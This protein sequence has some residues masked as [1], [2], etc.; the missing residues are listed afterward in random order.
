M[1]NLVIILIVLLCGLQS[2]ASNQNDSL[3]SD[4]IT[5]DVV[6]KLSSDELIL[7]IKDLEAMKYSDGVEFADDETQFI[8]QRFANPVFLK[9]II[10][11]LIICLMLFIILIISLPFYF[12]LKKTQS[13][14]RMING[15]TGQNR[16]IPQ[17]LIVGVSQTRSD[18]HKSIILIS[19][20]I[21]TVLALAL[22]IDHSRIWAIGIIPIV[23]GIGHYIAYRTVD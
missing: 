2:Y 1:K 15:F 5:K 8:A 16:E 23:I 9:G 18:L 11:S 22:L 10:I 12:N 4:L 14:H 19:L 6:E 13:F 3:V 20:G 7:L 21:G 17:E